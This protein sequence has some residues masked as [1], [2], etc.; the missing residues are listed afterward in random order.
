MNTKYCSICSSSFDAE[1]EG[2]E[3]DI[4]II[5]VAFC[6]TCLAGIRDFAEQQWDLYP[7]EDP[8]PVRPAPYGYCP[9][10]GAVGVSRERRPDGDDACANGHKYPS[11]RAEPR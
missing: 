11:A 8:A 7:L 10:C 1:F 2:V 9:V 4:G 5:P 3:G 6:P